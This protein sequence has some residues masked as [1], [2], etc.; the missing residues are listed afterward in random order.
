MATREE[1][2]DIPEEKITK[3]EKK[4]QIIRE[5]KNKIKN[6]KKQKQERENKTEYKKEYD[7]DSYKSGHRI[8]YQFGFIIANERV[9]WC[10]RLPKSIVIDE[11]KKFYKD[12]H[13]PEFIGIMK[14]FFY[15]NKPSH[16][17]GFMEAYPIGLYN[18]FFYGK[19]HH[20]Q[21]LW[22]IRTPAACD[23]MIGYSE[24]PRKEQ[25]DLTYHGKKVGHQTGMSEYHLPHYWIKFNTKKTTK[26][27]DCQ[28]PKNNCKCY[29]HCYYC[30][31]LIGY[32]RIS[33]CLRT[34]RY[35]GEF[36]WKTVTQCCPECE[37]K[38]CKHRDSGFDESP[39]FS[40]TKKCFSCQ[41]PT[42]VGRSLDTCGQR[43][44][45]EDIVDQAFIFLFGEKRQNDGEN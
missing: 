24:F 31:S 20:D 9:N 33:C 42:L 7:E 44:C 10:T 41:K 15:K 16:Q 14:N 17:A 19:E 37:E 29:S 6:K 8:G 26:C 2:T 5:K 36:T 34:C 3:S 4:K 40:K 13:D 11:L 27:E 25:N 32:G 45:F 30:V 35:C 22:S 12:I 18:G 43:D 1:K 28:I 23:N 39:L 21:F 38:G